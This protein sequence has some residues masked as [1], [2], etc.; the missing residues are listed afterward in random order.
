[1]LLL[2]PAALLLDAP[3]MAALVR[4]AMRE[5]VACGVGGG[6]ALAAA[7]ALRPHSRRRDVHVVLSA[8]AAAAPAPA[9]V[10]CVAVGAPEVFLPALAPAAVNTAAAELCTMPAHRG[11]VG[12]DAMRLRDAL[13]AQRHRSAVPWV[14]NELA[15]EVEWRTGSATPQSFPPEAHLS[16]T[17]LCNIECQFCSYAHDDAKR[18]VVTPEMVRGLTFLRHARTLRLHSGNGEPTVNRHLAEILRTVHATFDHVSMNFFT[19]GILLDRP[20]LIDAILQTPVSW[21][22][23]SLN[24]AD[25]ASWRALCR[26][27]QFDRVCAN[28]GAVDV[29]RREQGRGPVLYGS[30]V[31]TRQTVGQLPHMPALC[32]RLGVDRFTA[33]PFFSLGYHRPD[34][35]TVKEAYHEVGEAYDAAYASAVAAAR[36]HGVTIELPRP[37]DESTAAFGVETRVTHDFAGTDRA[38]G[39]PLARLLARFPFEHP[40]GAH[41]H[42]LWRQA[43]VGS[44]NRVHAA[45]NGDTHY[46]Y[47]CLGPL[48]AVDFASTLPFRFPDEGGF[49]RLWNHPLLEMLRDGQ[50]RA[51]VSKVCDACRGCDSRA[52][53]AANDLERLVGEFAAQR[54]VRISS[55]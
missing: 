40:E 13:I 14:F 8:V 6:R 37:R 10:G 18:D 33:I 30:M 48:A 54:V 27:D 29:A 21:I 43:A 19:N 9:R 53:R 26:A 34:R 45:A 32:R 35:F 12:G 25:A 39:W 24:A 38:G 47:P 4:C 42:F 50:R 20:G 51:G 7:V 23:V 41:C 2:A 15:N 31:L 3:D 28:V 44:V 17:G 5:G 16:V 55:P 11:D 46:L 1:L 22:S 49:M 52:P 36:E